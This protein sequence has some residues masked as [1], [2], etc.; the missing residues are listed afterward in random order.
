MTCLAVTAGLTGIFLGHL[1]GLG[2][3]TI[4]A[5]FTV[6][7]VVGIIGERLDNRFQ[8]VSVMAGKVDRERGLRNL[9]NGS[10]IVPETEN[11]EEGT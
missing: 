6:G 4:L 9:S 8:F 3:G 5:A 2:I 10:T 11:R 1:D 7:K